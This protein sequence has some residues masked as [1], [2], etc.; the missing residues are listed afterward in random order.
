[1][2]PKIV[3]FMLNAGIGNRDRKCM[4]EVIGLT[5][6]YSRHWTPAVSDLSLTVGKGE[7][8]GFVGLNG[9]GKTTTIK[10][11]AGVLLPSSGTV[12]IDGRDIVREKK[13]ASAML[14]WIPEYPVFE[15]GARALQLLQYY[16]GFVP[17]ASRTASECV[18]LLA[19]V[20]LANYERN[21]LRSYSQGMRKRFA[22]AVALVN[23]PENF[24]LDEALN[25]LDPEGIHQVRELADA[26]RKDGAS[27]LLSSHILSEVQ[28]LSTGLR[29]YTRES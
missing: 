8:V 24:L 12:V 14:G 22:L 20:G 3:N 17:S 16:S 23:S 25:G 27:V 9:A 6:S 2:P 15:P 4:I 21:K 28:A 5:K 7:I 19:R 13:E 18:E 26:L 11:G 29:S 10:T 1:M